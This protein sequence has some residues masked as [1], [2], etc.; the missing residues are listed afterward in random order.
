MMGAALGHLEAPFL[1][2]QGTGF[3]ALVSMGAILG[4]TMRVPLTAV[5]FAFE[6]THDQNALLPVLIASSAAYALTV[7]L[8]PRSILTEKLSRRG[9][10]VSREYAIDPLE[11]LFVH[12]VMAS[13]VTALP[14]QASPSDMTEFLSSAAYPNGQRLYPV[15][16]S[17]G[18][19]AGVVT[20]SALRRWAKN[21]APG[22]TL[23]DIA[24][25]IQESAQ[26]D[27]SLRTV[28]QRMAATGF[29]QLPVFERGG[30]QMERNLLSNS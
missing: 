15:E 5:V 2:A 3:W 17:A 24:R 8:L 29:T 22:E 19:V 14:C 27:E 11:V 6:L 10:H 28:A 26:P 16:D 21:A 30:A 4:G 7:L 20:R 13:Y 9:F 1:P 23:L 25:P 12:E 18:V